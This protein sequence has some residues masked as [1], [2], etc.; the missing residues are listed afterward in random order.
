MSGSGD[1]GG[2]KYF[3]TAFLTLVSILLWSEVDQ[4]LKHRR[5]A[6][7]ASLGG[8]ETAVVEVATNVEY[9]ETCVRNVLKSTLPNLQVQ[10]TRFEEESSSFEQSLSVVQ[11]KASQ[12]LKGE[13]QRK[14]LS[15]CVC[16]YVSELEESTKIQVAVRNRPRS[17]ALPYCS[18]VIPSSSFKE[19]DVEY[20]FSRAWA[21]I[22]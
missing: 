9:A 3:H 20:A 7:L 13:E 17:E 10:E 1:G 6:R 22:T 15:F 19:S 4:W 12:A 18:L 11:K 8:E 2:V 21:Q 5:L 16:I 14:A